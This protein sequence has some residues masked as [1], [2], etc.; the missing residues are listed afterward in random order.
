MEPNG[1]D[2]IVRRYQLDTPISLPETLDAAG[3]EALEVDDTRMVVIYHQAII[4]L[5]ATDGTPTAA[6]AIKAELWE[7]PLND[8]TDPAELLSSLID[9]LLTMT[10]GSLRE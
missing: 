1:E 5:T 10:D 3:I 6:T 2:D 8:S 9:E 4:I 7:P